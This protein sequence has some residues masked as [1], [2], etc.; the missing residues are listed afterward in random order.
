MDY[1]TK[2]VLV[3]VPEQDV[4][5]DVS[6]EDTPSSR[7]IKYNLGPDFLKLKSVVLSLIFSIGE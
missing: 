5:N 2:L 6:D 1:D 4:D 3:D 7:V